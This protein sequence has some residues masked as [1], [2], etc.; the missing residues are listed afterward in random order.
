MESPVEYCPIC[1]EEY[2]QDDGCL[3][4]TKARNYMKTKKEW[5]QYCSVCSCKTH[6]ECFAN[7]VDR[8]E[9]IE[10][11]IC[12]NVVV[13]KKDK[14]CSKS[15]RYACAP[16]I[17]FSTFSVVYLAC[18]WLGKLISINQQPFEWNPFT[19]NHLFGSLIGFVS[20]IGLLYV[21]GMI[22]TCIQS[23]CRDSW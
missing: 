5:I 19:S 12:R 6:T 18:G 3:L 11:M 8:R 14:P 22:L 20:L 1:L 23:C 10:C 2:R 15:L 13:V 21:I 9:Q 7:Y 17:C 4:E 16:L